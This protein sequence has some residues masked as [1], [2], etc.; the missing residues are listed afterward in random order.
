M[1]SKHW[2]FENYI[3]FK[4]WQAS[5]YYGFV[6]GTTTCRFAQ[7]NKG[8]LTWFVDIYIAEGNT[9]SVWQDD[10]TWTFLMAARITLETKVSTCYGNFRSETTTH[11]LTAPIARSRCLLPRILVTKDLSPCFITR[12]SPLHCTPPSWPLTQLLMSRLGSYWKVTIYLC[13]RPQRS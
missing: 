4:L 12:T 10:A 6:P 11:F 5:L 9:G 2:W 1:L 3:I 13:G 8:E 7:I